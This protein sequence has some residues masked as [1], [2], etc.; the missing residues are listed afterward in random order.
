MLKGAELNGGWK[1]AGGSLE[2][3]WEG[4]YGGKAAERR[5]KAH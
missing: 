2:G 1:I 3:C 5:L 4:T